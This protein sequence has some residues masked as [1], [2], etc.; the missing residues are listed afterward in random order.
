MTAN[1]KASIKGRERFLR[2]RGLLRN[3]RPLPLRSNPA[4]TARRGPRPAVCDADYPPTVRP[5]ATP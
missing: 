5:A 2:I 4:A 3:Q 1:R